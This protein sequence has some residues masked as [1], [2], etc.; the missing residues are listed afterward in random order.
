[1]LAAAEAKIAR[2][3]PDEL[4]GRQVF[5]RRPGKAGDVQ[6][7][8]CG[9]P[10]DLGLVV[11][12]TFSRADRM[13]ENDRRQ[14]LFW[15]LE[16][17]GD[18]CLTQRS[19]VQEADWL[20]DADGRPLSPISVIDVGD[21]DSKPLA[22]ALH[23]HPARPLL[24]RPAEQDL[25]RGRD[26]NLWPQHIPAVGRLVQLAELPPLGP[27]AS[28]PWPEWSG[29]VADRPIDSVLSFLKALSRVEEAWVPAALDRLSGDVRPERAAELLRE[30]TAEV[31]HGGRQANS[32]DGAAPEAVLIHLL[33]LLQ[34]REHRAL[35]RGIRL[36]S[37]AGAWGLAEELTWNDQRG[38][39]EDEVTVDDPVAQNLLRLDAADFEIGRAGNE[40]ETTLEA[41][42]ASVG[43][44]DRIP[45][46]V[47]LLALVLGHDELATRELKRAGYDVDGLRRLFVEKAR[48]AAD[49]VRQ[50]ALQALSTSLQR[51]KTVQDSR[52]ARSFARILAPLAQQSQ[53]LTIS[54]LLTET[55]IERVLAGGRPGRQDIH[56]AMGRL[57]GV[58]KSQFGFRTFE[59]RVRVYER[60]QSGAAH[61]SLCGEPLPPR[62]DP[63]SAQ[64]RR[65]SV[66]AGFE[67][68]QARIVLHAP[69]AGLPTDA[70]AQMMRVTILDAA[71]R[72]YGTRLEEVEGAAA[73]I[74]D[75]GPRYVRHVRK[76]LLGNPIH[77]TKVSV[78]EIRCLAGELLEAGSRHG[79]GDTRPLGNLVEKHS[80]DL[81]R[82]LGQSM[83]NHGYTEE[84]VLFELLQNSDDAVIQRREE[85]GLPAGTMCYIDVSDD[86]HLDFVHWGRQI[87]ETHAVG[88]KLGRGAWASDLVYMLDTMASGKGGGQEGRETGMFGLGFKSVYAITDAPII[89]GGRFPPFVID[90]GCLP[91]ILDDRATD[92]VSVLRVVEERRVDGLPP[93]TVFR[94]PYRDS[95]R[96]SIA[97]ND[98]NK[99]Q[100]RFER[101]IRYALIF[102]RGLTR[103]EIR[104]RGGVQP[105]E[106]RLSPVPGLV[107]LRVV[108]GLPERRRGLV[109]GADPATRALLLVND[110][111]VDVP[112]PDEALPTLWTTAPTKVELRLPLL[113]NGRWALEPGR[114]S[115]RREASAQEVA[116]QGLQEALGDGLDTLAR[117]HQATWPTL[118]AQLKL[119]SSM[120]FPAFIAGLW[121]AIRLTTTWENEPDGSAERTVA[122]IFWSD[123]PAGTGAL[124]RLASAGGLPD[125]LIDPQA[126]LGPEKV[127]AIRAG[128]LRNRAVF[129]KLSVFHRQRL[130]ASVDESVGVFLRMLDD[131]ERDTQ[132][133]AGVIK[134][135]LSG[136]GQCGRDS[137][138]VLGRCGVGWRTE[139]ADASEDLREAWRRIPELLFQDARG[140]W[141]NART[142]D[143]LGL[144]L[145]SSYS[146]AGRDF[147]AVCKAQAKVRQ[148]QDAA[149]RVPE[150]VMPVQPIEVIT[151]QEYLRALAVCWQRRSDLQKNADGLD[152]LYSAVALERRTLPESLATPKHP[153][154]EETWFRLL[155]GVSIQAAL[156][157]WDRHIK[158]LEN[159][160]REDHL[161]RIWR[162]E[163]ASVLETT[164][165]P[166]TAD[167]D[168]GDDWT[169]HH[170]FLVDFGKF[171]ALVQDH[172]YAHRLL[173]A[174]QDPERSRHFCGLAYGGHEPDTGRR[175]FAA[176]A[177]LKHFAALIAR[178]LW[179]LEVARN[180]GLG[181]IAFF[182][183]R[184]AFKTCE[185]FG[186]VTVEKNPAALEQRLE[187]VEDIVK[188]IRNHPKPAVSKTL[189]RWRDA[190][191]LT[192]SKDP[193]F[194]KSVLDEIRREKPIDLEP[195][196]SDAIDRVFDRMDGGEVQ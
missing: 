137:A 12:W 76:L 35:L 131:R 178:E 167:P 5:V 86:R 174:A 156:G 165:I 55:C 140:S 145:S 171:R 114:T 112:H 63:G 153:G 8:V 135:V 61:L 32:T 157:N 168:S 96:P 113:L 187:Q 95:S 119:P 21:E 163:T 152:G 169:M 128:E 33:P 26:L 87:G 134:Q 189:D 142:F 44:D 90:G 195:E 107:G 166:W 192:F 66:V 108:E 93:P 48:S 78:D 124:R 58:G 31:D 132:T 133:L 64:S 56:E 17:A 89:A 77:W 123:E 2:L 118:R 127:T 6:E 155:C 27:L 175:M 38:V 103:I 148:A 194:K 101:L 23:D 28:V 143:L 69:P 9:G 117:Q 139:E 111:G 121:K 102:T 10:A 22:K 98:E 52:Q 47:G 18:T 85:L 138:D 79:T 49:D 41:I 172:D 24:R 13:A 129:E 180:D 68:A 191:F 20:A 179:R 126:V 164:T 36:P 110:H 39:V 125:S 84:S 149:R 62:A 59:G 45:Q 177:S 159:L 97:R 120:G 136:S 7:R 161:G 15:A 170:R 141:L 50:R 54:H 30:L 4:D 100:A 184:H 51:G 73:T 154:F 71:E 74:I 53:L 72:W 57:L 122:A 186:L 115:I 116:V 196:R 25:K 82:A 146:E 88:G 162:G 106:Q 188:A 150:P 183:S 160:R 91:R 67:L 94:L 46:L 34:G 65:Q 70:V 185:I 3:L 14:L 182:L 19:D 60:L 29:G 130:E 1:V 181:D 151:Q 147:F 11:D 104:R 92:A 42:F 83:R 99:V 40:R 80:W 173:K 16:S 190:P 144:E 158:Y 105:Y 109:F 43:G 37:R 176:R 75:S 193:T 81:A